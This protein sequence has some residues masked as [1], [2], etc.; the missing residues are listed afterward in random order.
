MHALHVTRAHKHVERCLHDGFRLGQ[1]PRSHVPAGKVAT[2]GTD[3]RVTACLESSDVRTR[4]LV[5]PHAGVHGRRDDERHLGGKCRGGEQIIGNTLGNLGDDVCR[6]GGD[7][8][9]VRLLG[10]RDVVD[11]VSR[12]V[13]ELDRD[14]VSRKR[15]KS[16]GANELGGMLGHDD[17][18]VL[19]RLLEQPEYFA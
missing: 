13:E 1:T 2:I 8:K 11:G 10:E 19:S 14:L 15:A 18:D 9:E 5:V 4:D 16:G 17:L 3:D 6:G 12:L 7:E